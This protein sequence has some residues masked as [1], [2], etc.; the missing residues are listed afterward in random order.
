MDRLCS[1]YLMNRTFVINGSVNQVW[2]KSE[3]NQIGSDC[4][5]CQA[6]FFQQSVNFRRIPMLLNPHVGWNECNEF[7]QRLLILEI[8]T[9]LLVG[10]ALLNATLLETHH[11]SEVGWAQTAK[12]F[13]PPCN[14]I[15]CIRWSALSESGDNA[16]GFSSRAARF[17]ALARR[18]K[19]LSQ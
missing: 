9:F 12:P 14:V 11:L 1:H 17:A 8:D 13:S 2:G 19:T 7:H 6:N 18:P 15:G 3:S 4:L 5:N 10:F 16:V